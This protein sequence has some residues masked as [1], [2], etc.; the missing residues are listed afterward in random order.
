MWC[1]YGEFLMAHCLEKSGDRGIALSPNGQMLATSA[2]YAIILWRLND[3]AV[4]RELSRP[5]QSAHGPTTEGSAANISFSPDGQILVTTSE[6]ADEARI[7]S[8]ATGKLLRQLPIKEASGVAFSPDGNVVATGSATEG[9]K[10]WRVAD[11]QPILTLTGV[12]KDKIEKAVGRN[13]AILHVAY[14][15]DGSL[16]AVGGSNR[17]LQLFRVP[18]GA[19]VQT[20]DSFNG[21]IVGIAFSPDG[22][23]LIAG[24][25]DGTAR[26]WGV[27]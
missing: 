12:E 20:F 7:W 17:T 1:V 19:R 14:S 24:S 15:P 3:G 22:Q 25:E 26:I 13:R 6:I 21:E 10:L 4:A 27:R 8:I 11:G 23:M 5:V 16:L 2:G 18:D 9:I